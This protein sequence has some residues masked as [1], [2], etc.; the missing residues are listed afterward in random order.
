MREAAALLVGRHD[1]LALSDKRIDEDKSTIVVVERVEL[2]A[3]GDLILFR[4]GA[5]HFLWKLVRRI[6]GMLV[7]VGRESMSVSE[8]GGLFSA[9]GRKT[10]GQATAASDAQTKLV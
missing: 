6:V 2:A 7:E 8:F 5:S 10:R 4:I 9:T 1:F 3:A